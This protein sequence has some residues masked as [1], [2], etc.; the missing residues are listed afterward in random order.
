MIC[1]EL[2]RNKNLSNRT[3]LGRF[4]RLHRDG[5]RLILSWFRRARRKRHC[6]PK[7]SF[8]PFIFTWIAFNGWAACVTEL[9]GD[10]QWLDALSLN[11]TMCDDFARL[12]VT[13]NCP[14]TSSARKF[15]ELWPVFKAQAIRRHGVRRPST[16]NR[17][18]II[19]HYLSC[20]VRFFQPA[21]WCRHIEEGSNVL[22]D[23]PHT[24]SVLYRVRCNLFHGEKGVNSE[25]DARIVANAFHVLCDFLYETG[26]VL[27]EEE[28]D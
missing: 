8:E 23:W 26:Y 15:R 11:Q 28:G 17:E 2:L 13:K 7:D 5:R 9:D 12:L 14:L 24:L 20:G 3:D 25:M 16:Q 10:R 22:L 1:P 21:C 27:G 18:E 4:E 19:N 6:E